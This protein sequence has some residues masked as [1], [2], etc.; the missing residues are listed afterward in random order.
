[1][2]RPSAACAAED[3]EVSVKERRIAGVVLA[4]GQSSRMGRDKGLL[5]FCGQPLLDHMIDLLRYAGCA[6]VFVSGERA[7]YNC[8]PDSVPHQGP[9]MAM[10]HVMQRLSSFDGVLFVPV[11]M[12][13][14]T[15]SAL[16]HL[17]SREKGAFFE[18]HPLPAYIVNPC[19]PSSVSS[20]H[21]FI[22]EIGLPPIACPR[23][24]GNIFVN[25]NTP[26]EWKK[27]VEKCIS[28]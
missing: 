3:V 4:G 16:S 17:L 9:A 26:D 27:E 20:V 22:E 18:G 21:E 25:L 10:Q 14:L 12:P 8:I 13:F 15:P 23:E 5:S 19:V 2:M 28:V 11:D 6:D 7:G 24:G 1:M